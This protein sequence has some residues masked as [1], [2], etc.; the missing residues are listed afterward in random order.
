M[1]VTW[2]DK[3]MEKGRE[4]GRE[5]GF[6]DGAIKGKRET[7]LRQLTAKFGSVSEEIKS[8]IE[9]LESVDELDT[10]LER[11]LT[12]ESVEEMGL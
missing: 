9:E 8:R 5:Q 12:A 11:V 4:E 3:M 6:K 7:L 1:E 2:A 10:Y